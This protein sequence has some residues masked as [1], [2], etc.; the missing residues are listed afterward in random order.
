VDSFVAFSFFPVRLI[1]LLGL[2]LGLI[3]LIYAGV[4]LVGKYLGLIPIDGW[5]SMMV[6]L[7][8]VSSFQMIGIGILGEYI[9]R[10]LDASRNRPNFI[11]AEKHLPT[12]ESLDKT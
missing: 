9:W 12:P 1:S 10:T 8:L 4:V 5:S 2:S 7:L 6:I 3:A 11:V